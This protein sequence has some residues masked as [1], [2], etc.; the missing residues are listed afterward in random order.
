MILFFRQKMKDDLSQKIRENMIFSL[1][2][3]K[4]IFVF[5][6]N[7]ILHFCQKSKDV[8]FRKK[9]TVKSYIPGIIEKDDIHPR[10]YSISFDRKTEDDKNVYFYEKVPMILFNGDYHWGFHILLSNEKIKEIF[11]PLEDELQF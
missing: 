9:K 11:S 1:F 4:M 3:V 6:T 7:I 8:L 2:S 5:P 10:K